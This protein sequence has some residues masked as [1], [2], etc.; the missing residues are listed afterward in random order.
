MIYV[1]QTHSV[2]NI[3]I[4]KIFVLT[5]CSYVTDGITIST[6]QIYDLSVMKVKVRPPTFVSKMLCIK[7]IDNIISNITF[8]YKKIFLTLTLLFYQSFVSM[9]NLSD[10][11][12]IY[13]YMFIRVNFSKFSKKSMFSC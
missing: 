4:L 13:C 1:L 5:D 8:D 7:Q 6:S 10:C 11:K 3:L 12:C 2:Y 9:S